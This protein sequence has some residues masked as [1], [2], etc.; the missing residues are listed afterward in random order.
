VSANIVITGTRVI[1]PEGVNSMAI[2]LTNNGKNAAL[3]QSWIDSGDF[4]STPE[5]SNAPFYISPPIIKI[6]GLQGQQLNLKKQDNL[7]NKLPENVESVFYLNVLDIPK[8][9]DEAKGKNTIQLAT[10]SRIK[11]FY[12]PQS[13]TLSPGNITNKVSYKLSNGNIMVKNDSPYHLTIASI[14]T[15]ENKNKSLIESEMIPPLST[16]ELP[17]NS[18]LNSNDLLMNYVDDYGVFKTK[19]IRL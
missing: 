15:K 8:T 1:Y 13:L 14:T 9:A 6:N 16:R 4:N 2:Q 18:K 7:G 17:L 11:I 19:P 3:V 5:N 12:R 10:R